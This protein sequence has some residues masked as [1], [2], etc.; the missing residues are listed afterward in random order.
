MSNLAHS[1]YS[2]SGSSS[3]ERTTTIIFARHTDVHNPDDVLYGRLPR[4][5][6]SE[7]GLRQA[8]RS[9]EALA[10]EPVSLFYSSPQLRARQTARILASRHG[11]VHVRVSSLL[12][13]VLT[14]W[15]GHAH[16]ELDPFHFDFYSNPFSE[17]DEKLEALWGRIERF[18]GRVRRKHAGQTIVAVTHGDVVFL[19]RSCFRGMPVQVGSIRMRGF[20]PGKGSLTRLTFGS[21]PQATYPLQVEYYDPNSAEPEWSQGWVT[22]DLVGGVARLQVSAQD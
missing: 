12:A 18:V 14:S 20:Y 7:L 5:G 3:N 21:D 1:P 15:Q 17:S 8:E 10:N 6:L 13:E 9:A 2:L 11:D 16:S 19:V 22:L 4:F